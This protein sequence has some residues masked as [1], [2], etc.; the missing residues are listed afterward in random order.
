[1]GS[2]WFEKERE[3]IGDCPAMYNHVELYTHMEAKKL[4]KGSKIRDFIL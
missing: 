3:K 2:V 1:L 4:A